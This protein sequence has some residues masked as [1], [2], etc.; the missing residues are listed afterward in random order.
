G[1]LALYR[2]VVGEPVSKDDIF[3]YV[4]GLLHDPTY[5]GEYAA[6]LKKMLPHIPTPT[7][8]ERF[9]QHVAAGRQLADLHAN[10]ETVDPY[11][12][13]VQLKPGASVEDRGTWQVSKM[14]WGKKKDPDTGRNV[15]D[16]S[17]IVYN[18]KVTITGIPE[19]AERFM[20]GS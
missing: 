19:D 14:K 8:R 1:I 11:D 17:V 13:D 4:Y 2:G 15:D 10:Y 12:L 16:R 3:F 18:G 7:S 20:L 6:D 9:E 5:R